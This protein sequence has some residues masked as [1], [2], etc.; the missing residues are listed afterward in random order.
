MRTRIAHARNE[1]R[2]R[3]SRPGFVNRKKAVAGT[4]AGTLRA[5]C[6]EAIAWDI[7]CLEKIVAAAGAEITVGGLAGALD[8]AERLLTL[9]ATFGFTLLDAVTGRFCDLCCGMQEKSL[10]AT[11]PLKAHLDAMRLL[12]KM[13]PGEA[14]AVL[15]LDE[16]S[17]I[18]AHYGLNPPMTEEARTALHPPSFR[19]STKL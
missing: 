14:E 9:S 4:R 18:R 19:R 5:P 12:W 11:A 6:E 2:E 15:I 13:N 10:T 16:L 3:R 7:V 1:P 8:G 17:R